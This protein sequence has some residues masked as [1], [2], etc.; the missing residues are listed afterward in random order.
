MDASLQQLLPKIREAISLDKIEPPVSVSPS[1]VDLIPEIRQ[2]L[3]RDDV[4]V[5]EDDRALSERVAALLPKLDEKISAA[6]E[7][8][9]ARVTREASWALPPLE[10]EVDL[11]SALGK[12]RVETAHTQ[13]LAYLMDPKQRHGL[14][15][16]VLREFFALLGRVIPGEDAFELLA[17]ETEDNA[18]RL[19]TMRVSAEDVMEAPSKGGHGEPLACRCDVWIELLEEGKSL[20]VVI[21]NK[22]DAGEHGDQ[23]SNYESAVW[24]RARARRHLNFE[25]RLVFLTP[26]GRPPDGAA[27]KALWLPISYRQLA[28][29]LTR[30]AR[31]A[32]EPGRTLLLLYVSSILR[33]VLRIPA[34]PDGVERARQLGFMNEI[35]NAGGVVA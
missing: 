19:R 12:G 22:I 17:R 18:R 24:Q 35:L 14:G 11:L 33:H 27:D 16:S 28:G 31:E 15:V 5:A 1:L 23:L 3:A 21:E 9:R 10:W 20:F 13:C 4:L 34:R 6:Y 26:D 8:A 29:A 30:A 25:A 2:A 32:P 7:E